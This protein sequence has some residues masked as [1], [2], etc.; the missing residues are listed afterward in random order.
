MN[1]DAVSAIAEAVGAIA[2]VVSLIYLAIQVRESNRTSVQN[3]VQ[4]AIRESGKLAQIVATTPDLPPIVIRGNVG[5]DQLTAEEQ[6]RYNGYQEMFFCVLEAWHDRSRHFPTL[7]EQDET[8]RSMLAD[9]F[10]SVG[11]RQWWS[12][13][14][15]GFPTGFRSWVEAR[16]D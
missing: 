10:G 13:N 1:W 9:R 16:N 7:S 6:L 11:C 2:V 14:R 4:E 15:A 12:E 3:M 5:L 8:V